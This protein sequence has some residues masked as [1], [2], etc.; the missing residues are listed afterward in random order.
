[1]PSELPIG[2]WVE[3]QPSKA[4]S[5]RISLSLSEAYA[6]QFNDLSTAEDAA[7]K[8]LTNLLTPKHNNKMIGPNARDLAYGKRVRVDW[9]VK[10][11]TGGAVN[12]L[13]KV[14]K[15]AE[16]VKNVLGNEFDKNCFELVAMHRDEWFRR[17]S[18]PSPS[19]DPW[20]SIFPLLLATMIHTGRS[21]KGADSLPDDLRNFIP[22]TTKTHPFWWGTASPNGKAT[23]PSISRQSVRATCMAV[24]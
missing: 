24:S 14:L 12:K 15:C 3:E 5:R 16:M 2:K 7:E 21:L 10:E 17:V 22:A 8:L 1:M 23:M 6:A 20:R 9:S 4:A 18:A 19:N 11:Y 13:R